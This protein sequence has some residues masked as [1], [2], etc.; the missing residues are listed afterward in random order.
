MLLMNASAAMLDLMRGN[1]NT[2]IYGTS[3]PPPTQSFVVVSH[4]PCA[5]IAVA[6]GPK[7]FDACRRQ[8]SGG[9]PW[10]IDAAC[11]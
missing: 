1:R 4:A 9:K 6:D 7:R 10:N 5:S 2:Q 11:G 3:M 8:V